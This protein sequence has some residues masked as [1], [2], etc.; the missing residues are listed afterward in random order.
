MMN[1]ACLVYLGRGGRG[2]IA[3]QTGAHFFSRIRKHEVVGVHGCGFRSFV[4]GL[5]PM[6]GL[7]IC[8]RYRLPGCMFIPFV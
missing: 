3:R 5:I 8:R 2:W 7:A 1:Q 4:G 6:S